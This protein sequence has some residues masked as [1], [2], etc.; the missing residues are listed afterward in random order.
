[1]LL[2]IGKRKGE[3]AELV[4]SA[5]NIV[6]AV[7]QIAVTITAGTSVVQY[8]FTFPVGS[9]VGVLTIL[10]FVLPGNVTFSLPVAITGKCLTRNK[11]FHRNIATVT[12]E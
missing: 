10:T 11:S 12:L 1:M 6:I 8:Y 7:L 2:G 5:G 4:K 9:T 3:V